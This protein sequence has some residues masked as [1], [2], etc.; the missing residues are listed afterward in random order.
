MLPGYPSTTSNTNLESSGGMLSDDKKL[1][2]VLG[3]IARAEAK[4]G[5]PPGSVSLIAVSKTKSVEAVLGVARAGVVHFGENYVQEATRK[6]EKIKALGE[7]NI[8]WHHI[9]ALQTNKSK[10]V[11][12]KFETIQGVDR[13]E[14]AKA[15]DARAQEAG[16]NQK[17]LIQ[18]KLG[19]EPTKGG[20][21]GAELPDLIKKLLPLKN[22][23]IEGLMT[24]PP[25]DVEPEMS[26]SYF[27][28]LKK[29]RDDNAKFIS[30]E[31]GS[32]K[33]LSMGTTHDFEVAIE[34]GATM[35]RVGTA[36]F[37]PREQ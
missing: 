19:D 21:P 27:S 10:S 20:V 24:L 13:F 29:L 9:G 35:V 33:E 4:A 7:F 17:I 2:D 16:I 14:L 18:V 26:R 25:M 11:V 23:S 30:A 32:F 12:G 1:E 6:I 34:E 31:R 22:L 36:I 5:R 15:L 37:G 3:R 8:K 28:Q